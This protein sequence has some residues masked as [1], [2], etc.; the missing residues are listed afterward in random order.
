ME[1]MFFDGP[2]DSDG[3]DLRNLEISWRTCQERLTAW[4][5]HDELLAR[6]SFFFR[7]FSEESADRF[8][9]LSKGS[10]MGI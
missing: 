5:Y 8:K 7:R 1:A 6:G 9:A 3:R 4:S 2:C 10:L